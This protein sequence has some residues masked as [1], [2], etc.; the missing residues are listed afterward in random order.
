MTKRIAG[1]LFIFFCTA[2]A[3][4][5]L[6]AIV[7]RGALIFVGAAAVQRWHSVLYLFGAILIFAAYKML[8]SSEEEEESRLLGLLGHFLAGALAGSNQLRQGRVKLGMAFEWL[9]GF[10]RRDSCRN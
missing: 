7:C 5:I 2:V 6:G 8:R 4:G 3:W 10:E 1:I 9:I